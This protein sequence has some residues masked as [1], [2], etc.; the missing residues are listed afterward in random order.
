MGESVQARLLR[1]APVIP[2]GTDLDYWGKDLTKEVIYT[3]KNQRCHENSCC[4]VVAI[5]GYFRITLKYF[6]MSV[7]SIVFEYVLLSRSTAP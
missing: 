1:T 3:G 2:W 6:Q 5:S 7:Y 4:S